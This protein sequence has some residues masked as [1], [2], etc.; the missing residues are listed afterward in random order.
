MLLS[1]LST[2]ARH[3]AL[4]AHP[5]WT[6]AL[7]GL[8]TLSPSD[9]DATIDWMPDRKMFVMVQGYTT[10]ARESCRFEAHRRYIDIQLMLAGEEIIEIAPVSELMP[11][12]PFDSDRD[13]GFFKTP[14]SP[15][16]QLVL[17]PGDFAVFFPE[18]AHMPKVRVHDPSP[19]R[20]AVVKIDAALFQSGPF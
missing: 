8:S 7:E 17:R 1:N 19:L 4:L 6:R 9:P 3:A 14:G 15:C 18:D 20:K 16:T 13:L 2:P 11:D 10:E 12:T 5:V